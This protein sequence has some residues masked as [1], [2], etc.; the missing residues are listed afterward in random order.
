MADLVSDTKTA[1][2]HENLWNEF[3]NTGS[4][5]GIIELKKKN[6]EIAICHYNATTNILPGLHLSILTD[7]TERE[8]DRRKIE[9]QAK[10][11]ECLV[12]SITDCFFV[13]DKNWIV[14][15]WN[16][17]AEQLL[18]KP[19]ED[20]VGYNL[21]D[22]YKNATG[23]RFYR[24]YQKAMQ[25]RLPVHFEEYYAALD[26]W[27]DV[28]AYPSSEGLTIYFRDITSKKKQALEMQHTRKNQSALI[29]AT[30]DLI[31]SVDKE[32][33]LVSFNTAYEKE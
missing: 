33:K 6:G 14:K 17:A 29:N 27:L 30:S 21:W 9:E 2:R 4:Q 12:E 7:I 15:H 16:K 22:I 23:L 19:K 3:V 20:V 28:S 25:Q 13:V 18:K 8:T 10:Y 26:L 5:S 11:I 1:G 31:W 32:L 24:E